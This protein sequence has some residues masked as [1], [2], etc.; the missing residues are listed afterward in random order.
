MKEYIVTLKNYNDLQDFY[1][2]M[3][4]PGGNLYIPNRQV[5]CV[6]RREI[7]RNTHYMLTEEE[8]N[9]IKN[10]P[11]VKDCQLTP[12]ELG[13]KIT[14]CWRQYSDNWDKSNVTSNS[15]K[16]WALL[17]CIEGVQRNNW[18]GFGA[19]ARQAGTIQANAE[20]R[21]V[22][23][24]IV[25]GLINPNHPEMAINNDGTG[26]TRVIHYNWLQHASTPGNYLYLPRVNDG[27]NNHGMHVAG[28]VAGNTQG[29]AR[30]ANIY[31]ITPY[32]NDPNNMNKL[33]MFDYIRAWH[34]SKPINPLT[35][36]RNPTICNNS[37]GYVVQNYI[38]DI[39]QVTYRGVNYTSNL[40][41][42]FLNS[43]GILNNGYT[44]YTG[45]QYSPMSDDIQLAIDDGII[46]IGAAG[47][48]SYKI[49]VEGGIDYD[50]KYR[51][52][53][54][55]GTQDYYYHRGMSPAVGNETI[56]VGAIGYGSDD[57]KAYFSNC[58]P[59]VDIYAPGYY[60]ISSTL[61]DGVSDIRGNGFVGKSSGTSMASPQVCGVMACLLET[62]PHLNQQDIRQYLIANSKYNQIYDSGGSYTDYYSLQGG[63]N[64][65]LFYYKERPDTGQTWPKLNYLTRPTNGKI[66]P[67]QRVR[68]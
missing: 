58:G 26:G 11:R 41:S 64:R 43:V 65:Y 66:Y 16:N 8:A 5:E 1:E 9:Q 42:S 67:R 22:D 32:G 60:I 15:Q 33:L 47:N 30:S 21:N 63:V 28:T 3:E 31:N 49:D 34:N 53:S 12:D 62:Y 51:A 4:T 10:D 6:N 46:V 29:W 48:D 50:N 37:W 23:V 20:G 24:V 2:D 40:T 56:S 36:R 25:D 68:R 13:I 59:R 38:S 14:P 35:G 55:Y 39:N 61:S 27:D 57:S 18:G 19:A 54:F 52:S 45:Y 17:R 44:T 7:S